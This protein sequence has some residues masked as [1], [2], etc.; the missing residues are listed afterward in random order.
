MESESVI[1]E[2][3]QASIQQNALL[4]DGQVSVVLGGFSHFM[5]IHRSHNFHHSY[6]FTFLCQV[7]VVLGGFSHFIL[8]HHSRN[9]HHSHISTSLCQV[10]WFSMP[11]LRVWITT[12]DM[13][14]RMAL[15]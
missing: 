12:S 4:P 2:R 10:E 5:L 1:E 7:P 9:F 6:I 13:E 15:E 3:F 11:L 14:L 8:I